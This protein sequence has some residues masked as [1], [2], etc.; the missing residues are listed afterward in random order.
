MAL[1]FWAIT[2]EVLAKSRFVIQSEAKDLVISRRY[3]ILRSLR[4]LR[5]TGMELFARRSVG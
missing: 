3:E 5:M 4:S 1:L 2:I